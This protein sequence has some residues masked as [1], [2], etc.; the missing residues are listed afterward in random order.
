MT[1][2]EQLIREI[3]V[4]ELLDEVKAKSDDGYRLVQIGCTRIEDA[5]EINYSFDKENRFENLRVTIGED[6]T[7]PSISDIYWGAFIYENEMHDLYGIPVEGMNI[8]FNGYLFKT[9]IPHP[10]R[11]EVTVKKVPAKKA[12]EET[13]EEAKADAGGEE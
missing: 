13:K 5:F 1:I 7:M 8:D 2:E 3:S 6:V 12:V 10:F 4:G 11:G 9:S